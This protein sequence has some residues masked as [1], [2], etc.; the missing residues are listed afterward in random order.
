M[1]EVFEHWK[2]VHGHSKSRLDDKRRRVI[3]NALANYTADELCESIAGYLN[4]P[5]HMGVNERGTRYDDIELFLRDAKH[6]DAG[7][8]FARTPP[9]VLSKTTRQNIANT[10]DW[11]PPEVR[12]A[13][14]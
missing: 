9:S 4:S 3:R 13:A 7:L 11:M 2:Q 10:A 5:H 14:G 8:Q 6:I 12:N 1:V